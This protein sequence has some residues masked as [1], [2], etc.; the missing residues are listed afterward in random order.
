[1]LAGSNKADAPIGQPDH[2][3][4]QRSVLAEL[5]SGA[6]PPARDTDERF[7][8]PLIEPDV[9]IS[10]IRL[11]DGIRSRHSRRS[12]G[13]GGQG[14]HAQVAKDVLHGEAP[15]AGRAHFAATHQKAPNALI[16][17]AVELVPDAEY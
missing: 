17:E 5:G 15:G 14:Q 4:L 1:M 13:E 9:P 3:L 7:R 12:A 8:S 6:V 2:V 16:H 10:V 11:S